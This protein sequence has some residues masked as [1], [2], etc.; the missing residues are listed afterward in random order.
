MSEL[1]GRQETEE[2]VS[3]SLGRF[4]ADCLLG[5]AAELRLRYEIFNLGPKNDGAAGHNGRGQPTSL[6]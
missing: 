1:Q 2:L 3:F 4:F 6:D 5:W